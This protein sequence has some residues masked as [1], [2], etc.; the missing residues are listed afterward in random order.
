MLSSESENVGQKSLHCRAAC[1]QAA[2]LLPFLPTPAGGIRTVRGVRRVAVGADVA[3]VGIQI[4][5][6]AVVV[7]EGAVAARAEMRGHIRA[8][9]PEVSSHV[10]VGPAIRRSQNDAR[11][12][13]RHNQILQHDGTLCVFVFD[14][15]VCVRHHSQREPR[16]Y[17]TEVLGIFSESSAPLIRSR[18]VHDPTSTQVLLIRFR[19]GDASALNELYDRHIPRI[20]AA[21][22]ARLGAELR[23]KVESWDIVQDAMLASLK[24]VGSF[25]YQSDGAFLKWLAQIVENRIRDQ[26]DFNHA[27]RRDH[28]LE[29]PLENPHSPGRCAPLDIPDK[30]GLR[31]PSQI[32]MLGEDLARLETAMDRLPVETRELIIAVKLEGRTFKEMADD[33]GKTPDAVR[34]QVNRAME[35]LAKVFKQ[36]D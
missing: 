35:E 13:S 31:T 3:G 22:R 4:P 32:L 33:A 19:D 36:L 14:V 2:R 27:G 18:A 24:N 25:E 11:R 23:H 30:T 34:M 17:R 7:D 5:V 29:T 21:V 16:R 6:A 10:V 28:R 15:F 26:L 1:I 9:R 12:R 8:I 20:L